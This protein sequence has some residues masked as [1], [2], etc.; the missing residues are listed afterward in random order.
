MIWDEKEYQEWHS[1]RVRAAIKDAAPI[2]EEFQARLGMAEVYYPNRAGKA[3]VN[4]AEWQEAQRH[5]RKLQEFYRHIDTNEHDRK[6]ILEMV[7]GKAGEGIVVKPD[8]TFDFG[9]NIF[10]EDNSFLNANVTILD[11]ARVYIGEGTKVGAN[12]NIYTVEH[13]KSPIDRLDYVL[14]TEP[15]RIGKRVWIAGNCTI[16]GGITIGD[17]SIIGSGAT[18][19]KDVPSGVVVVGANKILRE[20]TQEEL[21]LNF[22]KK[23]V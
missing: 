16:F 9:R 1:E 23:T 4:R 7:L 13:T 14:A 22:E 11:W 17:Y 12:S 5:C 10:M 8:I 3:Y 15:M 21:T 18:V 19:T 6:A 20:L 2:M